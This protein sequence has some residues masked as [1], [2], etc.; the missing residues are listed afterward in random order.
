MKRTLLSLTF[1]LLL[2][3]AMSGCQRQVPEPEVLKPGFHP[4]STREI[5]AFSR[6]LSP[7]AQKLTSWEEL[8][9]A[10]RRSLEYVS[11]R[12]PEGTALERPEIVLTWGDLRRSL[13]ILADLLPELSRRPE[14]LMEHFLWLG[15]EPGPLLTGYYE[16]LIEASLEPKEGFTYPFYG[17]PDDLLRVDLGQF[18]PR[19]AGQVLFYRMDGNAIR[20]YFGR[21][22]IDAGGALAGR[23][24]EIAWARDP[25]DIF[26]LQ[27]QGSGKLL[28]PDG[29]I[30]SILYSGK[31]GRE[32]V[33]LG[34]VLI[35]RGMLQREEVSMQAIRRVLA[36]FP[37]LA[38]ELLE[39]NP[40]YVFFHLAEEGP[41]GSMNKRLTPWVSVA[42][43]RKLFPL[44]SIA[45][46][47]TELPAEGGAAV[48]FRGLVLPQDTGGA[49][50]DQ[51]LDLFCGAG[52]EAEFVAGHLQA[53]ARVYLLVHRDVVHRR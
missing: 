41:Y 28:L 48:T 17:L 40:S 2:S 10:V 19:W 25:V 38:R 15:L 51:R 29:S 26:F 20:P 49:I 35:Q 13:E 22:E 24:I 30:R 47:E 50:I 5:A 42:T 14:L 39:T 8:E 7:S 34:K 36:E 33:S 9:P 18:H 12:D 21:R 11:L 27:I 23:G 45:A 44:G 1:F 37:D 6:Q 46:L 53:A 52:A 16:P 4:A 43:D 31:N 32:Y 3:V